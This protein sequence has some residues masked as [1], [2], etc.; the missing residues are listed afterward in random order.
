MMRA[1]IATMMLLSAA[2]PDAEA[3]DRPPRDP[4]ATRASDLVELV[5]LDPTISL[6]IRYATTNNFLGKVV[7][8]EARAF[9]HRPAA[10]ALVAAHRELARLNA[11]PAAPQCA[12]EAAR[13]ACAP[14]ECNR[15]VVAPRATDRNDV[16]VV[17]P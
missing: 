9:L 13:P 12:A 4:K 16:V 10:T 14:G 2:T 8:P 3:Q 7:Y 11:N 6:D 15:V 17:S 1:L 5:T